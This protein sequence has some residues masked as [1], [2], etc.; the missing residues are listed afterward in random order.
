MGLLPSA[1]CS[2]TA[3]DRSRE[4]NSSSG[5]GGWSQDRGRIRNP[6]KRAADQ[7][8]SY[9][10]EALLLLVQSGYSDSPAASRA[11]RCDWTH[12]KRT[13]SPPLNV[14]TYPCSP[15]TGTPLP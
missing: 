3:R 14:Q 12:R 2:A 5:G 8:R 6:K 4:E 15:A 1:G 10:C 7:K 11:S 9:P 13:A